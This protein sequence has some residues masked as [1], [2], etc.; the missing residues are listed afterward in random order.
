MHHNIENILFATLLILLIPLLGSYLAAVFTKSPLWIDP[1]F[2]RIERLC[3]SMS[4]INPNEEM[5]WKTYWKSLL[6]FNAFGFI[7][8]MILQTSQGDL[9]LNPQHFPGT[10]WDLAFNTS[11]S[12]VTNT[13][14]Q[15]YGGENTLSYLTQMLGLA[16]QNFLSAATGMAVLVALIRGLTRHSQA[17]IGN[18]WEDIVKTVVYILLPLSFIF[19]VVLVNEGVIQNYSPYVEA[20]T[21]EKGSQTIPMG[22]VASQE[23]IKQLGTNGGGFFN[24]N[25][26]HPFENPTRLS[27]F[28]ETLAI[29][30]I[31]AASVYMFGLMI[32]SRRHG[33][34]LL[35]V[36]FL[37]W[38]IGL[39]IS[40]ISQM[41]VD[42]VVDAYPLLEGIETRFGINQSLLW[43][44][45]TTATSNGSTNAMISSLSP[46][47]GGVALFNMM[48]GEVIFGGVGVGLC[49][50]IMFVLLTVFLS[51]LMV[52]R[53]P[54]Y[55]GKKI[56]RQEMLWVVLAT[57]VPGSLV[58]IGAGI[59][60][61]LPQA[62]SS[63]SHKG[64]HGLSE[65]L[66]AFSSAAANNG[67]AFAGINA[68]TLYY[69]I[70]LGI[71][72]LCA[73]VAILLPSL[74]VAGLLAQKK[75]TPISLGTLSTQS[76]IFAVLLISVIFIVGALTF[77]PALS[78]GPIIEH[79]LMLKN[80]SF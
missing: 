1:I 33:I 14:W 58:L 22:P 8:L 16:V 45:S 78:L 59:S 61:V 26:A 80:R 52:G 39:E 67:S 32:H 29:L 74:A 13:N 41:L 66:Y 54:E 27:N 2:G 23:A 60:S 75:V 30:L 25:S 21:L 31:P 9:P 46:L 50:M 38:F 19:A 6:L 53:T 48:L 57:L 10:S 69:N 77:F 35:I 47:A 68:N 17:T 18:F 40:K 24:A 37:L 62:I 43:S 4:G 63:L 65:V 71:V 5:S 79:L 28:L 49:G 70:V 56:D 55:L 34:L 36:M 42:P 3:Y 15:A 12:F 51:G 76:S 7:T 64:P 44:T 73:R 72:M 11:M 20:S